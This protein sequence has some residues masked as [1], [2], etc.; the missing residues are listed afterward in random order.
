MS[1]ITEVKVPTGMDNATT[2][3]SVPSM[4]MRTVPSIIAWLLELSRDF[5]DADKQYWATKGPYN[6]WMNF[7]IAKTVEWNNEVTDEEKEVF[8]GTKTLKPV[9]RKRSRS[10]VSREGSSKKKVH[11]DTEKEVA[12]DMFNTVSKA[13]KAKTDI[14]IPELDEKYKELLRKYNQLVDDYN[15]LVKTSLIKEHL[16]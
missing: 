5:T 13:K 3:V 9:K 4:E 11:F 15:N 10:S 1:T 2:D 8:K 12:D 6:W 7:R 14:T 16:N